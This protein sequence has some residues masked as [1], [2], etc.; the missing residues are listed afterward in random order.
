MLWVGIPVPS[1]AE[2]SYLQILLQ[3]AH[4][5]QLSS[6]RYWQL[7]LH[8]RR[9]LLGRFQSEID[10]P[11]FFY[12]PQG[13]RDPS[14]ELDATLKAFFDP[15][16]ADPE[17]TLHPQCRFPARYA[18][19]HEELAIDDQRLPP[20]SCERFEKWKSRMDVESASLV[21]ASYYMNNPAS[22]Y[23]HT[24]LRFNGKNRKPD[25][26]LLDYAVNYGADV[27]TKSDVLFIIY[28]LGGLYRG[29][30][31]SIPYYMKVQEYNNLESRDLWEY[32]LDLGPGSMDRLVGHLWE[33]GGTSQ[34]YFFLNKN[35]SYELLPVLE[36]AQPAFHLKDPFL[37]K[38]IP[39]DT[40]R[41]TIQAP[42]AL[43]RVNRR[44]S[45]TSQMLRRRA[46]LLERERSLTKRLG[47]H[48]TDE[49]ANGKLNALPEDRQALVLDSAYDLFRYDV[50]F[51]R[52][53]PAV[54]LERERELLLLRQKR[55]T[56]TPV[57]ETPAQEETP[58]RPDQMHKTGRLGLSYGFASRGHFEELSIRPAAHDQDDP[59]EGFLP[60]SKLEMFH[61]K[62]RYD[63]DR[64]TAYIQQFALI[65]FMSL[66]SWDRWIHLP[67]WKVNTGLSVASDLGRDPENSLTYGL[68][69][70]I[71]PSLRMPWARNAW[72]Y[73]MAETDLGV[74]GVF[75]DAYRL[76]G[77]AS[78]GALAEWGKWFRLRFQSTYLRYPLG[79][80][81]SMVKLQLVPSVQLTN[82]L[83]LRVQLQRQSVYKEA[84]F[85]FYWFL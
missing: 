75:R 67:S 79:E 48:P 7:L 57:L 65:D 61:L 68:N 80:P 60:A 74:G 21:F 6:Q 44:P 58:A 77:G 18:W 43:V 50:G 5:K 36:V 81:G 29:R 84:L 52:P 14:A 73:A 27:T 4:Q 13:R 33:L 78:G 3:K 30:F 39:V 11:A 64:K 26:H 53:Q 72:V 17:A 71:G 45:H 49:E 69:L 20:Q 47:R 9:S 16:P 15:A 2:E 70:G 34:A 42:G 12:S 66:T 1:A 28:G 51:K 22:M 82:D 24:F 59:S 19:L 41:Q 32:E 35:C 46:G 62:L 85:S 37:L 55:A 54:V 38:T 8:F 40:L 56:P 10:D 31:S 63:N 83:G 25:E 76:G 23:G